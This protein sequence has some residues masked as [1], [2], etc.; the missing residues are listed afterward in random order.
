M[1]SEPVIS[2]K[3]TDRLRFTLKCLLVAVTVLAVGLAVWS[4]VSR[5]E[6]MVRTPRPDDADLS[7][8]IAMF[9]SEEMR[10]RKI[11]VI[12]TNEW[13]SFSLYVV[14][15]GIVSEISTWRAGRS[16]N[17]FGT[18]SREEMQ[19]LLALGENDDPQG[20]LTE[21]VIAGAENVHGKAATVLRTFKTTTKKLQPGKIGPGRPHIIY[22]EGDRPI[23]LNADMSIQDFAKKNPGNYL[24]VVVQLE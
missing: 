21:L 14:Q 12:A 20:I 22:V 17:A 1:S 16:A 19:V 18:P 7:K 23:V 15:G 2:A 11:A 24:V 8:D 6:V 9:L 3:R 4:A 5:K 13:L 10:S